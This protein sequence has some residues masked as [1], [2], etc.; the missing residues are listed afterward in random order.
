M[1]TD[2]TLKIA[3]FEAD[4]QT[5]AQETCMKFLDGSLELNDENWNTYV[6]TVKDM[7]MD[8]LLEIY[9]TVYDEYMAGTR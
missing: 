5:Y 3:E 6:Q 7:G 1:T 2:E 4:M 9:Q 8:T